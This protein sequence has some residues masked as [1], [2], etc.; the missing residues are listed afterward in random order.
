MGPLSSESSS[1]RPIQHTNKSEPNQGRGAAASSKD[2][3]SLINTLKDNNQTPSP[4]RKAEKNESPMPEAIVKRLGKAAPLTE[5]DKKRLGA[6]RDHLAQARQNITNKPPTESLSEAVKVQNPNILGADKGKGKANFINSEETLTGL[7]ARKESLVGSPAAKFADVSVRNRTETRSQASSSS[8]IEQS[9]HRSDNTVTSA[10]EEFKALLTKDYPNIPENEKHLTK[11]IFYLEIKKG[12]CA[13][14]CEVLGALVESRTPQKREIFQKLSSGQVDQATTIIADPA[15]VAKY[16]A[17]QNLTASEKMILPPG[18]QNLISSQTPEAP[19]SSASGKT[20]SHEDVQ[21]GISDSLLNGSIV[22]S[23][24]WNTMDPAKRQ[25]KLSDAMVQTPIPGASVI[26]GIC[27]VPS[28]PEKNVL[29]CDSIDLGGVFQVRLKDGNTATI[30]YAYDGTAHA[31]PEGYREPRVQ[32]MAEF[33]KNIGESLKGLD[34]QNMTEEN[35]NNIFRKHHNTLQ[36]SFDGGGMFVMTVNDKAF[37]MSYTDGAVVIIPPGEK[38]TNQHQMFF[39]FEGKSNQQILSAQT[40]PGTKIITI[41]DGICDSCEAVFLDTLLE[42]LFNKI[43]PKELS[44]L[45]GTHRKPL[46]DDIIAS[47]KQGVWR[48][49]RNAQELLLENIENK[50]AKI[51]EFAEGINQSFRTT[52]LGEEFVIIAQNYLDANPNVEDNTQKEAIRDLFYQVCV[53]RG[54]FENPTVETVAKAA[55]ETLTSTLLSQLFNIP[56]VK[57]Q[58]ETLINTNK[59]IAANRQASLELKSKITS[60]KESISETEKNISDAE[61]QLSSLKAHQ[62]ISKKNLKTSIK[63]SRGALEKQK[64]D[65][66]SQIAQLNKEINFIETGLNALIFQQSFSREKLSATIKE[67]FGE[68]NLSNELLA[69]TVETMKNPSQPS[70]SFKTVESEARLAMFQIG[71]EMLYGGEELSAENLMN[72]ALPHSDDDMCLSITTVQPFAA[73]SSAASSSGVR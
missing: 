35:I 5:N 7:R 55:N 41:T 12:N 11:P 49:A 45:E 63:D 18:L 58:C 22:A 16:L 24:L 31:K 64:L 57:S 8:S 72:M 54:M 67:A 46:I 68:G 66:K 44:E 13:V 33:E 70:L 38:K 20:E 25:Q 2:K 27:G 15:V 65:S 39:D 53:E 19:S 43:P 52:G 51:E 29:N 48:P 26:K 3:G 14:K 71:F 4:V 34:P 56:A 23:T 73:S 32:A 69:R 62:F 10:I 1:A 37:V 42:N 40:P 28:N 50:Q 9:A 36:D 59:E 30:Q 47:G 6:V 17:T 60:L 21:K 61:A